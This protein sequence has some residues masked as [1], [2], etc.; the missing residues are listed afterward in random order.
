MLLTIVNPCLQLPRRSS[1]GE[2]R[3][4]EGEEAVHTGEQKA[5]MVHSVGATRHRMSQP[6]I[7]WSMDRVGFGNGTG[8]LALCTLLS[9]CSAKHINRPI[10]LTQHGE[11]TRC[12]TPLHSINHIRLISL[13]SCQHVLGVLQ[14]HRQ[15]LFTEHERSWNNSPGSIGGLAPEDPE[16]YGL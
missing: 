7:T 3:E 5:E 6:T 4:H 8:P 11:M 16:A 9:S 12:L 10:R 13:R 1:D 15:I 14:R 2:Q